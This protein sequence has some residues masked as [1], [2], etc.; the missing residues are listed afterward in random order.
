MGFTFVWMIGFLILKQLQ[1]QKIRF[2][3]FSS[4]AAERIASTT[5]RP[6]FNRNSGVSKAT[7]GHHR[8]RNDRGM[9]V[10]QVG[11]SS[12]SR[13]GRNNRGG[14]GG[15]VDREGRR[16][17]TTSTNNS[18]NRN[19]NNRRKPQNNQKPKKTSLNQSDLDKDLES[20]MMKNDSTARNT[21]DMELDSYMSAAPLK[22]SN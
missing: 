17:A 3:R 21:L 7:G 20:Y 9:E 11:S 13:G 12:T 5:S 14:R 2:F 22:S 18:N 15:R 6:S 16:N 10:D 19:N 8:R 4:M 1:I